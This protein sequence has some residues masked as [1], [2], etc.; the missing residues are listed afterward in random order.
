MGLKNSPSSYTRLLQNIFKNLAYEIC[1]CYVDDIVINSKTFDEHLVHLD[2]VLK[3]L[4]KAN[5]KLKL[6]K[7]YFARKQIRFLGNILFA[8]GWQTDPEKTRV[9]RECSAPS[10]RKELKRWLGMVGFYRN[11]FHCFRV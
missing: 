5:R 11:S 4:I 1:L 3:R 8:D 9:I 10:N 2:S 6:A 7:C